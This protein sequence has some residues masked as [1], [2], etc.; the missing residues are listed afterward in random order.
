MKTVRNMLLFIAAAY[1]AAQ[2]IGSLIRAVDEARLGGVHDLIVAITFLV[3]AGLVAVAS[4]LGGV[5]HRHFT[6]KAATVAAAN[7]EA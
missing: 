6:L 5:I 4:W 3:L 2:F 1:I 7:T